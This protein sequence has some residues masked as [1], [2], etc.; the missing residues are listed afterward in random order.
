MFSSPAPQSPNNHRVPA[1][2]VLARLSEN[3]EPLLWRHG[4]DDDWNP[5]GESSAR[6]AAHVSLS[7]LMP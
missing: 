7:M 2:G 3:S 1:R 5:N 4:D 6:E